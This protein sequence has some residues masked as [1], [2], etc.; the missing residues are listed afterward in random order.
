MEITESNFAENFIVY[1]LTRIID[2]TNYFIH[3]EP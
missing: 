3:G 1:R 2:F